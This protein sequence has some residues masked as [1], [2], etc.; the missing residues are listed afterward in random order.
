[1]Y[2]I[3]FYVPDTHVESVKKAMFMAGAGR[4]GEYDS[5]CWQTLGQ[6]QF[7]ALEGS[8]PYLG[9]QGVVER[10]PELRVEMVC[11]DEA[12]KAAV[13]ALRATHPYEEPAFD[14]VKLEA[15]E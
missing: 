5:C 13:A 3:G 10:V 2:K 15:V 12:I 7:R 6:G 11:N 9:Q 1:M 14:V 4:M 8:Q